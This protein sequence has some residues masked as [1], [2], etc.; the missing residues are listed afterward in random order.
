MLCLKIDGKKVEKFIF[1]LTDCSC[2]LNKNSESNWK[3][4]EC[5][6]SLTAFIKNGIL[7]QDFSPMT[8]MIRVHWTKSTSS[9]KSY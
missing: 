5:F 4:I 9:L 1:P 3:M 7:L 6:I 2:N 8:Y